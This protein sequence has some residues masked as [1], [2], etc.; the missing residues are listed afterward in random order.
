MRAAFI[1]AGKDLRQRLR[2]RSALIIAFVAPLVLGLI[3]S[4]VF[5][6]GFDDVLEA[7]YVVVDQDQSELSK[8]FSEQVLR[9]PQ[10]RDQITVVNAKSVPDITAR[11]R[12]DEPIKVGD[13][14]R[15]ISAAFVIPVGF[16]ADVTQNRRASI[17]VLENPDAT[18]GSQVAEALAEGYVAQI[19]AGRLSVATTIAAR[20]SVDP[21]TIQ[22][23]A[24]LVAQTRIPVE[25][26]DGKIGVR[27][28]SGANYFGPAMGVFFLF[29]TTGFAA[30]SLITERQIGTLPRMLSAPIRGIHVV[31]GKAITGF[32]LGSLSLAVMFL[33]LGLLF[34]VHWGDPLAL[35]VLSAVTV[36]AIMAL[37]SVVQLSARTQ[38]QAET[39]SAGVATTLALLG[40]SFFPIFQLPQTIQY[41]SRAMP[42]AWALQGF[43][44]IAYDGAKIGD[45]G[46]NLIVIGAFAVVMGAIATLRTRKMAV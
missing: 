22:Q 41:I 30:R 28:I 20:G 9:A 16:Q 14:L 17:R 4:S 6:G 33:T 13:E 35:V 40:G 39:F 44:D 45:I 25:L 34:D 11:I 5:G 23:L 38:E 46:L 1:I 24:Q 21:A 18:I 36:V 26:V 37:A 43:S 29:F 8:A 32:I 19:N 10:L 3:I 31:A 2:D 27:D 12:D 42:N 15:T 7:T